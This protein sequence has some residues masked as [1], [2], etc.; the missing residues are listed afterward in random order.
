[1]TKLCKDCAHYVEG[2]SAAF[3][4]CNAESTAFARALVMVRG[5]TEKATTDCMDMRYKEDKCGLE[6][7][8]FEART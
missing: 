2:R 6:G 3:D 8:L 4:R 5:E 1:M 7:K